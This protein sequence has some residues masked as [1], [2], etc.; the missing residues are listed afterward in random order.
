MPRAKVVLTQGG[1]RDKVLKL[2]RGFRGARS[3]LFRC[4]ATEAVD[5]ASIMR[6]AMARSA[7]LPGSLDCTERDN[8]FFLTVA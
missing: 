2:A 5:R 3:K 8:E 6:F 4:S 1:A 7:R